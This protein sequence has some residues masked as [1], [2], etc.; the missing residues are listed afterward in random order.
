MCSLPLNKDQDILKNG[1]SLIFSSCCLAIIIII[2]I[3]IMINY[4]YQYRSI[5]IIQA[6]FWENPYL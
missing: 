5:Y 3:I 2:I 1:W 4:N 6:I